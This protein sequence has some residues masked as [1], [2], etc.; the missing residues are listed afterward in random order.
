[1]AEHDRRVN[2]EGVTGK[3]TGLHPGLP[4]PGLGQVP[5]RSVKRLGDGARRGHSSSARRITWSSAASA[6]MISSSASPASTLS[7]L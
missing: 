3:E 7:S 6:S 1:M 2:P 4:D 5:G